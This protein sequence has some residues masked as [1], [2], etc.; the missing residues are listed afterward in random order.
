[1]FDFERHSVGDGCVPAEPRLVQIVGMNDLR[2]RP[3]VEQFGQRYTGVSNPATVEIIDGAVGSRRPHQLR[4]RVGYRRKCVV[5]I[6]RLLELLKNRH[7]SLRSY[8]Q[9]TKTPLGS[10]GGP[11]SSGGRRDGSCDCS[12]RVRWPVLH[13]RIRRARERTTRARRRAPW[14]TTPACGTAYRLG[15]SL[16]S[17]HATRSAAR[18]RYRDRTSSRRR[19]GPFRTGPHRRDS[20]RRRCSSGSRFRGCWRSNARPRDIRFP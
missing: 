1:M 5:R 3:A 8:S 20:W 10:S 15:R 7:L 4:H 17:T 13:A 11:A 16:R 18:S 2:H 19:H 6:E 9:R 12:S 14:P